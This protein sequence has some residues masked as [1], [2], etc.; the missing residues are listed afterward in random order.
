MAMVINTNMASINAQRHLENSRAELEQAMERLASGKRVNSAADDA[1]GGAIASRMETRVSGMDQLVRNVNDGISMVQIAEAAMGEVNS[2]LGRMRDLAL[3]SANSTMNP[4]DRDTL[5]LEVNQLIEEINNIAATTQFNGQVLLNGA[6]KTH[7]IQSGLNAGEAVNFSIGGVSASK[8][9]LSGGAVGQVKTGRIQDPAA[10]TTAGDVRINGVDIGALGSAGTDTAEDLADTINAKTGLTG[11]KATAYNRVEGG[12]VGLGEVEIG[13]FKITGANA[14][15]TTFSSSSSLADLAAKINEQTDVIAEVTS[16]GRLILSNTTGAD[17]KIEGAGAAQAGLEDASSAITYKGFMII[18]NTDGSD[19]VIDFDLGADGEAADLALLGLM[20][21]TVAGA[22]TGA[23]V[24]SASSNTTENNAITINGV[25]IG[26]VGSGTTASAAD[27]VAAINAVSDQT[28]VSASALTEVTLELDNTAGGAGQLTTATASLT[29]DV[30]AVFAIN[31]T[32]VEFAADDEASDIVTA[33]NTYVG[34]MGIKAE[35][36]TTGSDAG[37]IRIYSVTGQDIVL[38]GASMGTGAAAETT[39]GKITLQNAEGGAI[40]IGSM[41]VT[42]EDKAT[43]VAKAG[44]VLSNPYDSNGAGLNINSAAAALDAVDKLDGAILLLSNN[45][46]EMGAYIK[47]FEAETSNLM[48]AIEKTSDALSAIM[49]ADFATESANL[50]RAQVLQQAGTAM[51]A[52]A[53][54]SA[55]NVLTLLK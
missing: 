31:G 52:Q 18:E 29:A 15:E 13:V 24:A 39:K 44:L 27:Y 37:K 25:S 11:V 51:L 32:K 46:A 47:R 5:Q 21:N 10:A 16:D 8:L 2:M 4:S 42:E 3:Q 22:V 23:K 48:V 26:A 19:A 38:A 14:T 40:T 30:T 49:D 55:Q 1:A 50:A 41:A 12:S 7:S 45:R 33:I 36:I 35:A 43:A 20:D 9:G 53:N 17:I 34:S 6:G 28:K 54:A